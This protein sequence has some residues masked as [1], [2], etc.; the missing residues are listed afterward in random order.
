[1]SVTPTPSVSVARPAGRVLVYD[2]DHFY[3][4]GALAERLARQGCQV[5]LAT[6]APLVSFWA[7]HTLEQERIQ[8]RL[9]ELGVALAPQHTL[10]AI[11]QAA[12]ELANATTGR[13]A[14]RTMAATS[15]A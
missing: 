12:A 10:R 3:M 13:S 7:Q 6:P 4:G 14:A 5:T 8:R 9:L 1:M 15:S 2:N 11:G